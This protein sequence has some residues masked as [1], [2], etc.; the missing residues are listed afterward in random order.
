MSLEDFSMR[1]DDLVAYTP[2]WLP[3]C[4]SKYALVPFANANAHGRV[5]RTHA[6]RRSDRL[7]G[8][9]IHKVLP[10][11]ADRYGGTCP[12][13][14]KGHLPR[15]VHR[16]ALNTDFVT[17]ALTTRSCKKWRWDPRGASRGVIWSSYP[18]SLT[19]ACVER[20]ICFR[21]MHKRNL[22]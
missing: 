5:C 14:T 17:C 22:K 15:R 18:C 4:S 1:R 12:E 2:C 16:A 13:E 20:K 21:D 7:G 8:K 9:N 19:Q 10:N 11:P 6:G 3:W